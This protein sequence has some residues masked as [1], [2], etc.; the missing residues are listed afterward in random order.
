MEKGII[1][2]P[3]DYGFD[4]LK[5]LL[6]IFMI[7]GHSIDD[8]ISTG[9]LSSDI[10]KALIYSFH[11][12]AFVFI[13]GYFRKKKCNYRSTFQNLLLPYIIFTFLYC[14][15]S[16]HDLLVDFFTPSY[17]YWY[18]LSMF[19]WSILADGVRD[20]V[21]YPIIISI[22]ISLYAGCFDEVN[23]FMSVSR[24]ICMFP[25][26]ILGMKMGQDKIDR[27]RKMHKWPFTIALVALLFITAIMNVNHIMP[28]HMYNAFCSYKEMELGILRGSLLRLV[29]MIIAAGITICL[30]NLIGNRKTFL[31]TIGNR[32]ITVFVI[33]GFSVRICYAILNHII[34][35]GSLNQVL[36]Y[37]YAIL[38]TVIT[39][40][41]GSN[42]YINW[43]YSACLSWIGNLFLRG[44]T[45]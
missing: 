36:I 43:L 16:R 8:F 14:L 44:E 17:I 19:F 26:F 39:I 34:D 25:F 37:L 24:T 1:E 31:S 4:A 38:V 28:M 33:S 5:G 41:I 3:R 35:A 12:P 21:K 13:S 20:Y 23:R 30:I 32:S 7:F 27:I 6:L 42:R 22:L 2:R 15:I 18:L 29:N 10:V 45:K 9:V 40:L 11:M